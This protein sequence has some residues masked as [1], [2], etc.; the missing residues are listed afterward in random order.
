MAATGWADLQPELL[1]IVTGGITELADIARF[2]SVC[3]TWRDASVEAAAAPPPQP[4]WLVLPSSP[5]R[6]F[7]CPREDR[8]YPDLRLPVP[9]HH[10]R[11]RLY[12]SPHG[13]ILAIDPTDLAASLLHPFT[14][15]ARPLPP[16]P[17][18]FAETDDL[19]WDM[20]PHGVMVSCGEGV[21]FCA[22]DPIAESWA[23]IPAMAD[24]NV[25]SINYALGDFFVFEEDVCRT[26]IVDA[27]TLAVQAVVPAP[28]VDLP[29]EARVVVAGD[30]LILLVKSKWMYIFGDDVDF[31]KA[32]H[33]SHRTPGADWEELTSIGE[34]AL[35]VDSFHGFVV[36]TAGFRNLESNTVY[37]VDTKEVNDRRSSTVKYSLSA[38]SLESRCS[39]KLA[40]QLNKLKMSQRG[41][42]PSWIIPSLNED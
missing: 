12:A 5:S 39:K 8:L 10:R 1:R 3:T 7:F 32:F 41:E 22:L 40:C 34:R 23:P 38:F 14:G 42:A 25:S 26:T 13:W 11:R 24:C 29:T 2:R 17:G 19:A 27:I 15:A 35:F 21:L 6:L 33:V 9:A 30:E 16:L 36:G 20:S 31:T 28:H 18:F 37:S 4:P